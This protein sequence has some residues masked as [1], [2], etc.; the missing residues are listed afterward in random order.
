MKKVLY[1]AAVAAL[2]AA[3]SSEELADQSAIQTESNGTRVNFSI[4]TPRNTRAGLDSTITT[5]SLKLGYHKDAGF[6]VFAYYTDD[7]N[8]SIKATPNF[9]YNQQVKYNGDAWGYE[10]VKYWPNE[11]GAAAIS[12]EVDRLSFFA[13]APWIEVNPTNGKPVIKEALASKADTLKFQN[14]NI[15]QVSNNTAQG[16]PIVK[17]VVDTDPA[18]SVD[19]LWGVKGDDK[20][21]DN[22]AYEPID[23][24]YTE[25]QN[26]VG[27]P[28]IDLIKPVKP[29]TE[30]TTLIFNLRHALAKVKFT[31]DYIDDAKT[32]VGPAARNLNAEQTRIFLRNLT[33][34]GFALEGALNLNNT[35]KNLPNWKNIN[36]GVSELPDVENVFNDARKDNAEGK[37]NGATK[38]D[39]SYLNPA[40]CENDD[41]EAVKDLKFTDKKN[42]GITADK[43]I[44]FAGDLNKNDGFFYVIPLGDGTGQIDVKAEYD[45]ETIDSLLATKLSDNI[46]PGIS[47]KNTIYK[48]NILQDCDVK[49]FQAGYQYEINIHIGMT[50]VKITASVTPWINA[51]D[52]AVQVDLPDNQN[53]PVAGG[54]SN[55]GNADG[56]SV[57][58]PQPTT[59]IQVLDDGPY[60]IKNGADFVEATKNNPELWQ[61]ETTDG[62]KIKEGVT[63]YTKDAQDQPGTGT[64]NPEPLEP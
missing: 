62:L 10:P 43:Q 63:F 31:I 40:I 37:T 44:L 33:I 41:P 9:M 50:S 4:Y 55:T 28:F 16:D 47:V 21:A 1:F 11:F 59:V 19:L 5:Q 26:E 39:N 64:Q 56:Y 7:A 46:T 34:N 13:Y 30:D 22:K 18:T 36:D 42:P 14:K 20:S 53:G 35:E 6:G 57:A 17:Y 51:T 23:N 3:C 24:R 38:E 54:S 8:Y 49:D 32:P 29:S 52:P 12:D 60:Y 25:A 45:V 61:E 2:F 58:N 15:I 48:E 27:L